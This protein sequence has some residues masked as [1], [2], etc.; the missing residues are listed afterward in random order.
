MGPAPFLEEL[1]VIAIL[2]VAV[3]VA[4]ARISLPTVAGCWPPVPVFAGSQAA[5]ASAATLALRDRTGALV[6][7]IRRGQV[8]SPSFDPQAPFEVGDIVYLVGSAESIRDALP[9][10]DPQA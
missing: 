4:L 6:V 3:T 5:G 8:L 1:A 7:A 2:A 10:F 9:L